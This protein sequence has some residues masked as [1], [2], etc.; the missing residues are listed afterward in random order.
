MPYPLVIAYT[1][2]LLL[3][4]NAK[5]I[6][7]AGFDGF[8]KDSPFNDETQE[9]IKLLKNKSGKNFVTSITPTKY[10]ITYSGRY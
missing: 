1:I 7:L 6:Y 2:C 4:S 3:S 5:K 10:N 9:I 8:T